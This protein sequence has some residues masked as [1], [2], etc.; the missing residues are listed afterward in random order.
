MARAS[1]GKPTFPTHV[2][3]GLGTYLWSMDVCAIKRKEKKDTTVPKK[4]EKKNMKG[5]W[6]RSQRKPNTSDS[7]LLLP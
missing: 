3:A 4:A 1:S 6:K 7:S 5:K 2:I